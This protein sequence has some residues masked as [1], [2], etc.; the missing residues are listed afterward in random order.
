M[1]HYR[2]RFRSW[3]NQLRLK[4]ERKYYR[5]RFQTLGLELNSDYKIRS[6]IKA[7][8]PNVIPK[9][10]GNLNILGIYYNYNWEKESLTPSLEK[11]GTVRHYDWS[12]DYSYTKKSWIQ[13]ILPEMNRDL[14][15]KV[16]RW[17]EEKPFDVIF[18]Y[19]SGAN[20]TLEALQHLRTLGVPM[21][22][23]SLNDKEAFVGKIINGQALGTRDICKHFDLSWTSTEDAI[24]KYCVEGGL[25]IYM[26]E[27]A[28][29]DLHKPYIHEE[30]DIDVSFVGQRYGNR[31]GIMIKLEQAGIYVEA[32]GHGWPNG[33]LST[34][35]MVRM[36][37]RSKIN[38]GFSEVGDS[39]RTHCLKGRD[40]EIPMSGG[41]YLTQYHK[42][43]ENCY[44]IGREIVTYSSF[45][46]LV[47]KIQF[48][49]SSPEEAGLIRREGRKRA[50][51]DH[52]WEMRFQRLFKLLCLI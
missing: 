4:R 27:G 6:V 21:A 8:F 23:M 17:H 35:E 40:F 20:V 1:R 25:P 37:S 50:I 47:S 7:K 45:D 28:N 31:P 29:P 43:L 15:R 5:N 16:T 18:S 32:F 46:E 12:D 48:L 14:I 39:S 24:E 51:R 19:F 10:K 30:R 49:L 33:S 26:P 38:L 13:N 36:Y 52:T 22:N 2:K 11:F 9:K 44:D 3:M 41:L 42:E 34:Q